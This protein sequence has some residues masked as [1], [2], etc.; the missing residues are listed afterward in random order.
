MDAV[1]DDAIVGAGIVGL[2]HAYHLGRQGRR[3]IVFERGLRASGASVRNFG[4]VWPIGQPAGPLREMALRSLD[5]WLE[6]LRDAKLWHEQCGSL[7]LAYREDEAQVLAEFIAGAA[8]ERYAG[9]MLNAAQVVARAP[10]VRADGLRG[11]MWSPV[12]TC[13]DPR[14]VIARLPDWLARRYGVRFEFGA[15][16]T[17]YERPTVLAA[18]K[19]WSAGRLFVCSG[20]DVRTLYPGALGDEGFLHCKLQMMRSESY[21]SRWRLGPML[22]GG[23]TLRHYH[24]FRDCPSLGAL[25]Q[26]VAREN[27]QYDRFGIHVMAAQNGLG[28]VVIGDS[29]E[30]DAGIE[31]FDKPEI[32]R[33]ILEYL[34]TFL[35]APELRIAARWHG[36]YAKHPR[37]AYYVGRPAPGVTLVTGV[38]GAGMTLSFGLAEKVVRETAEGEPL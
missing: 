13:V 25:K 28:E 9:T 38:G 30:Y 6:V 1:F 8:R 7:H 15:A 26:R 23:L 14:E 17:G 24:A 22:A 18:A 12:E 35:D 5:L 19:T 2:A 36:I 34:K 4:M 32:E 20:D 27:P 21:G 3:V 33:L 10:A 37:E 11:A 29:H 31:P 16:V